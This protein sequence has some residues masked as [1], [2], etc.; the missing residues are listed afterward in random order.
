VHFVQLT[1]VLQEEAARPRRARCSVKKIDLL[2]RSIVCSQTDYVT[3]VG[4]RLDQFILTKE[5]PN[6]GIALS[7]FFARFNRK[8]DVLAIAELKTHNR[9]SN[10]G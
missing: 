7:N 5:S 1:Q 3:L 6:G 4:N 10:P 8:A 9:M 2:S